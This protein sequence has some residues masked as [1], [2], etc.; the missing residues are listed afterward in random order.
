M[1]TVA[2]TNRLTFGGGE[3]GRR[4]KTSL[5]RAPRTVQQKKRLERSAVCPQALFADCASLNNS[6]RES[7]RNQRST[8]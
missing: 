8:L 7:V 3:I 5:Q 2:T 4:G 6:S 1:N